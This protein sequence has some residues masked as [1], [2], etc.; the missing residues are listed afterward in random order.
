[1]SM[2]QKKRKALRASTLQFTHKRS[3]EKFFFFSFLFLPQLFFFFWYLIQQH[4]SRTSSILLIMLCNNKNEKRV[5]NFYWNK[6][7][8]WNLYRGSFNSRKCGV[9][10]SSAWWCVLE[11]CLCAECVWEQQKKKQFFLFIELVVLCIARKFEKVQHFTRLDFLCV[12]NEKL[13]IFYKI[14]EINLHTCLKLLVLKRVQK[15]LGLNEPLW[16]FY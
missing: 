13:K 11:N 5:W 9:C 1:M 4:K 12:D 15:F 10:S 7:N 3:F 8:A 14:G 16:F 2:M 6:I